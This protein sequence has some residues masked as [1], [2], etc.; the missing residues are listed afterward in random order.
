VII[1]VARSIRR[2]SE[3]YLCLHSAI[4]VYL[5]LVDVGLDERLFLL[6]IV[7]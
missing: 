1:S 5:S 6:A 2:C 7:F 3:S 4:S